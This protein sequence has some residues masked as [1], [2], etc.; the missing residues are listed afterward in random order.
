MV[1]LCDCSTDSKRHNDVR[2]K[3]LQ[4]QPHTGDKYEE[5]TAGNTLQLKKLQ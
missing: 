4:K 3:A 5:G 1:K 2:V